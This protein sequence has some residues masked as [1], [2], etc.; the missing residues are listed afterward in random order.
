MTLARTKPP[1]FSCAV[2][3]GT[4]VGRLATFGARVRRQREDTGLSQE[5]LGF[6]AG[7]H[8]T[9]LSGIERGIRNLSVRK[10]VALAAAL[11]IDPA[12]LTRGLRPDR[13]RG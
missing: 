10:I 11:Q 5:Q 6:R 9:Y 8:P 3:R 2:G 13:P 12:E 7:L 4:A 1:G